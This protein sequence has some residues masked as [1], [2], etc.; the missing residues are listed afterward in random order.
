[1][2]KVKIPSHLLTCPVV[3][4]STSYGEKRDIM[5][6]TAMFI[7]EKEP[8]LAVSVAKDHLTADLIQ[9]SGAFTVVVA[10]EDQRD[11]YKKLGSL[12]GE[13][14]DK[15]AKLSIQT[16]PGRAGKAPVP[17]GAAGWFDCEVSSRHWVD[18]YTVVIGR[19]VGYEDREKQPLVWQKDSLFTLKEF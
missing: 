6:A 19:V 18:G 2:T 3:F 7:S 5:T 10:S 11:L 1:M 14:V 13:E 4:I 8:L 12:R 15:F 9:E 17:E 16:L